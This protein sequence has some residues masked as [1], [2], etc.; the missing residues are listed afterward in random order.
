MYCRKCSNLFET[1]QKKF[2]VYKTL[3]L[4]LDA[5]LHRQ[6]KKL[7]DRIVRTKERNF[8]HIYFSQWLRFT[9]TMILNRIVLRHCL[10]RRN[11]TLLSSSFQNWKDYESIYTII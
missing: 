6:R 4:Q 9:K 1:L 5:S 3:S 11:K 8:K 2:T 10:R 7:I